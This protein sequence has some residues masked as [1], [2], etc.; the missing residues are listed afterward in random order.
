M[1]ERVLAHQVTAEAPTT[2]ERTPKQ[3][4]DHVREMRDA[5]GPFTLTVDELLA[6][7]DRV[8]ARW[9]HVGRH[10]GPI[11]GYEPTGVELTQIA[12]A[13]YRVENGLIVEY[14]IQIDRQGVVA[15]LTRAASR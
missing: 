12:S 13:V 9:T 3:Y 5:Y 6:E 15:Q 14:W 1:A 10:V 8:Y 2:V 7:D 4:A 11:D